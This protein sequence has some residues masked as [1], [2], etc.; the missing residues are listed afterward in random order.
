M[1]TGRQP[2]VNSGWKWLVHGRISQRKQTTSAPFTSALA[3]APIAVLASPP[4]RKLESSIKRGE[5]A[6]LNSSNA[7]FTKLK[8]DSAIAI[9][10]RSHILLQVDVPER[11]VSAPLVDRQDETWVILDSNLHTVCRSYSSASISSRVS[12]PSTPSTSYGPPAIPASVRSPVRA[13][14]R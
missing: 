11:L 1:P 8:E 5:R 4:H 10:F 12:N 7:Q 6:R 3:S 13:H 9:G 2:L 14:C